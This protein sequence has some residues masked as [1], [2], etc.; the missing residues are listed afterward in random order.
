[1]PIPFLVAGAINQVRNQLSTEKQFDKE[2]TAEQ[3]ATALFK[4]KEKADNAN[5]SLFKDDKLIG[6]ADLQAIVNDPQSYPAE[7]VKAAAY[8]LKNPGEF[9]KIAG[10]H[11]I[12]FDELANK[13]QRD[14]Q[15]KAAQQKATCGTPSHK[16]AERAEGTKEMRDN[17]RKEAQLQRSFEHGAKILAKFF[18]LLDTAAGGG[19]KD[20]VIGRADLEAALKDPHLPKELR[21][22]VEMAL[23][24]PTFMNY[25]DMADGGRKDSLITRDG[26]NKLAGQANTAATQGNLSTTPLPAN[27]SE[28]IQQTPMPHQ[29]TVQCKSDGHRTQANGSAAPAQSVAP[30]KDYT[31]NYSVSNVGKTGVISEKQ[32]QALHSSSMKVQ[33]A[34]AAYENAKPE[35]KEAKMMEYKQALQ[36]RDQLFQFLMS[37]LQNQDKVFQTFARALGG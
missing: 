24:S 18:D 34:K 7:L 23:K 32:Y 6:Q 19:V 2:M 36:E 30:K 31:S 10:D 4:H 12:S 28:T 20:G 9:Q 26:I 15:I 17:L 11:L 1:M 5:W 25:L 3:A 8:F 13:V 29:N 22:V 14:A 33:D 21:E 35:E 37:I 27:K 16:S